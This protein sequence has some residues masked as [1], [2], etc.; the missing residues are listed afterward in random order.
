[1]SAQGV[2]QATSVQGL[3][4]RAD[5]GTRCS[6]G[7]G[8]QPGPAPLQHE[9]VREGGVQA[10][11]HLQ[12]GGRRAGGRA[13]AHHCCQCEPFRSFVQA[14]IASSQLCAGSRLH[15]GP[16]QTSIAAI[17]LH[18]HWCGCSSSGA[19]ELEAAMAWLMMCM[20]HVAFRRQSRLMQ[21]LGSRLLLTCTEDAQML[22]A[23]ACR[24]GQCA[25]V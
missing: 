22:T 16:F 4:S 13:P 7:Q 14:L 25:P 15:R 3:C 9:G 19:R 18:R 6:W 5:R 24:S 11:H 20:L 17:M 12:R 10:V 8:G 1:M 2:D 21:H 23:R